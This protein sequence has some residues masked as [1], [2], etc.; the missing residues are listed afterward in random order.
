MATTVTCDR[1]IES[2][3]S[4]NNA[5]SSAVAT[6]WLRMRINVSPL[7]MNQLTIDLCPACCSRLNIDTSRNILPGQTAGRQI[8][9][10]IRDIAFEE[11]E[12]YTQNN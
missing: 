8:T 9:D 3:V 11:V 12:S 2:M 5:I 6:G 4:S 1:C 10:I 7:L